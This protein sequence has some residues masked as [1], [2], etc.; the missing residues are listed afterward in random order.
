MEHLTRLQKNLPPKQT[1]NR[2]GYRMGNASIRVNTGA[3]KIEVNDDGEYIVL[4][5]ADQDFPVKFAKL[6][7]YFE[8]ESPK[9]I[10]KAKEI[11]ELDV[12]EAERVVAEAEFN[13]SFHLDMK[14]RIDALFGS[15]TCRKV[16]GDITP[17][18]YLYG[19]FFEQ[20]APFFT[21]YAAQ[22]DKLLKSKYAPKTGES[23]V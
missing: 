12:T 7:E 17:A 10:E 18:F 21:E 9:L 14:R 1:L 4:N 19:E 5:F 15:D 13:L 2:K 23:R 22:R 20:I 8:T 11:N 16:F 3:K 6:V